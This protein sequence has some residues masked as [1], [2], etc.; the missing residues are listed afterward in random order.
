M[1]CNKVFAIQALFMLTTLPSAAEVL[2]AVWRQIYAITA[3]SHA[4]M[5]TMTFL[6]PLSF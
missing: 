2:D 3:A 4:F 1:P 5:T 6:L